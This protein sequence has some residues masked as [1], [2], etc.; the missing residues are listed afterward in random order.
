MHCAILVNF[1][2][3]R[4]LEL[5][6][7]KL[8]SVQHQLLVNFF[9][10]HDRSLLPGVSCWKDDLASV[11]WSALLVLNDHAWMSV[12]YC[13][14]GQVEGLDKVDELSHFTQSKRSF[15]VAL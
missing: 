6:R 12:L 11:G 4:C 2:E 9:R 5:S 15:V 14:V 7:D 1:T 8:T 10:G 3:L 13:E